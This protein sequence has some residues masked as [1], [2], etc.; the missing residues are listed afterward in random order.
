MFVAVLGHDLRSPITTVSMSASNL[1]RGVWDPEKA[2]ATIDRIRR[3]ADRMTEM[4]S[5]LLDFTRT[6]LGSGFEIKKQR[7]EVVAFVQ[8]ILSDF[9]V[10]HPERELVRDFP[11][12]VNADFD[13]DRVRQAI[14]NLLNNAGAYAPPQTPIVTRIARQP[15]ALSITVENGGPPIADDVRDALFNPFARARK[16]GK[17]GGL[18]LG[19]YIAQE[20]AK[21]H[22]GAVTFT[23]D[24][25][26]TRFT[27]R[28]PQG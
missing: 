6:R 9:A 12:R 14:L 7:R 21:A 22:G 13:T 17:S 3:S 26:A 2:A 28:L 15:G 24:E 8:E 20:I 4:V 11:E 1:L 19:L 10:T 23:S 27:L 16:S 5:Q 18:G 25:D